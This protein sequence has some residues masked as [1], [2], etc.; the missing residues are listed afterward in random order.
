MNFS[1]SLLN[2]VIIL[3]VTIYHNYQYNIIYTYSKE[4]NIFIKL[5]ELTKYILKL[6]LKLRTLSW[7]DFND[8]QSMHSIHECIEYS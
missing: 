1:L 8:I 2:F 7:I 3:C 5:T 6:R 4:K